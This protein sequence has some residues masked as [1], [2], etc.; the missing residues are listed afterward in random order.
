[1]ALRAKTFF[2]VFIFFD[3][4]LA[5]LAA[6]AST[7]LSAP[8]NYA[9]NIQFGAQWSKPTPPAWRAIRALLQRAQTKPTGAVT[10]SY[11]CQRTN[12]GW[13]TLRV[14]SGMAITALGYSALLELDL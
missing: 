14:A 3:L 5:A 7:V 9:R 8:L 6:G 4:P 12:V 1:M 13:G 2:L 10:L 11:L